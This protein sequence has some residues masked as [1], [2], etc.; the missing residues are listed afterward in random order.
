MYY[1]KLKSK[2][3]FFSNM[4]FSFF[5]H[6]FFIIIRYFLPLGIAFEMIFLISEH[7]LRIS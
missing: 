3:V 7:L 6:F 4:N 5:L 1:S 2:N